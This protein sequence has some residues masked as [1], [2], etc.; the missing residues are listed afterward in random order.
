MY[1]V[2]G[3]Q[4]ASQYKHHISDYTDWIINSNAPKYVLNKENLGDRISMDETCLSN[5]ELYTIIT[6]KAAN[7]KKDSLIAMM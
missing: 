3:N 6:N 1:N 2:D 4:L 5:G 7:G